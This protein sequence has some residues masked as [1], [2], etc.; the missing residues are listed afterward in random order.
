MK[1]K[2]KMGGRGQALLRYLVTKFFSTVKQKRYL[3]LSMDISSPS[4]PPIPTNFEKF[5]SRDK[6]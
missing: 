6:S 3:S 1:N 4:S 5:Q 2:E